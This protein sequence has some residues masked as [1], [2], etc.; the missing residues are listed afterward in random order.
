MPRAKPVTPAA[1]PGDADRLVRQPD[2]GYR[3][4]DERFTVE[5]ANGSWYLTDLRT[6]DELGLPRVT[7]PFAT[8]KA[9][10]EALPAARSGPTSIR[11]P[12]RPRA[13]RA[14]ARDGGR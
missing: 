8:L 11:R 14:A 12:T 3:T 2:G 4:E 10:R 1:T 7:G 13:K 6:T 9:V 5:Q